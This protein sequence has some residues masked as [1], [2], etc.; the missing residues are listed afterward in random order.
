MAIPTIFCSN[1]AWAQRASE[2][3]P[4]AQ[5]ADIVVT[6]S[7]I[8]GQEVTTTPV[9]SL[10]AE[11]FK[12]SGA[13]DVGSFL[14]EIPSFLAGNTPSANDT[15]GG[16]GSSFLNLRGLGP[17]RTLVLVNG[18]RHVP[19]TAGGSLDISV[20]PAVAL[21]RIEVVTGGASAAWGSDAVAGV[22]N[23]IYDMNLKGIRAEAQY[24]LSQEGDAR[25]TH[26]AFAAGDDFADGRGHFLIAAEY[27]KNS[28][29]ADQKDRDWGAK[30]WGV[31][32]NPADTGSNDGIPA[33]LIRQ[34]A[35]IGIATEGGLILGP[36]PIAGLEF[37]PGGGVVPF[38]PGSIISPP[39]M[40]GGSGANFGQYA[41][42]LQ[43][44]NRHN[45][46][47]AVNYEVTE[48]VTAFFEGGYAATDG[49]FDVVQSFALGNLII[50][51]DNPFLPAAVATQMAAANLPFFAMGRLNTDMG[52]IRSDRSQRMH[53]ALVGLRG[54]L[55]G[56]WSWETYFQYGKART[57]ER[58][59]NNFMPARFAM[60]TD[61]VRDLSGNIV[62][63]AT[64]N[65]AT[66]AAAAGCVPLNP[67]GFGSP[68]AE[69]IDYVSGTGIYDQ[70]QTQTVFAGE[71]RGDIASLWA[72]PISVAAGFEYR[73][74]KFRGVGDEMTAS[75]AFLLGNGQDLE[76]GFEAKELFGEVLLP[77]LADMPF[78]KKLD[79]NAAARLTDY[80][81]VG[82]VT[83]WKIGLLW[84]TGQSVLLRGSISRDIRAPNIGEL[85]SPQGASFFTPNDPCDAESQAANPAYASSCRAA[86]IPADFQAN[87]GLIKLLTGG[88][89]NLREER[90]TTKTAGI[91]FRPDFLPRLNASIDWY[92]IKVA[93]AI[94]I[95]TPAAA[96]LERCYGGEFPN[97]FCEGIERSSAGQLV[98]IASTGLNIS[99]YRVKG[100]D[101]QLNYSAPVGSAFGAPAT[102]RLS[103]I[104]SHIIEQ[105]DTSR[106]ERIDRAG[107]LRRDNSGLPK[108]RVNATG[109]FSTRNFNVTTQVRYIGGGKYDN[110]YGPEDIEDNSVP[111]Q[112]YQ[113]ISASVPLKFKSA[114]L[115]LFVGINN[116][117]NNDP[118]VVPYEFAISALATNPGLYDTIGRYFYGGIRVRM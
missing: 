75:G 38:Q 50:T 78:I 32:R 18:R 39:Y 10:T 8:Q 93:D 1:A 7:R 62:C 54:E 31:I 9:L 17:K 56:N 48:G 68:S 83:T 94:Q 24:G 37:T 20:L 14:N 49:D 16:A 95:G 63:R 117:W 80:D 21:D 87:N 82:S 33:R 40:I 51:A 6:A 88:N 27:Q 71:I 108:W 92:D 11:D 3:E 44:Y 61:A 53:R 5:E 45:I 36:G 113:D 15:S 96:I 118:P 60:A 84:D 12:A 34:N 99:E 109:T 111:A 35:N 106:F 55:G 2:A 90:A 57:T 46:F 86:G 58:L 19:T 25:D 101:T 81:T 98:S 73:K 29:I 52:F 28:G 100:I 79:L 102:I 30:R 65:P 103:V 66:A 72:G 41:T 4:A 22:V 115:E 23:V 116:L 76:G 64:L 91:V 104:G 112:W 70:S 105:S 107:E 13:T 110:T 59:T 114:E 74:E 26:F 97:N 43:P 89:P 69:A 77:L 85:F 42:L 47:A 67:F